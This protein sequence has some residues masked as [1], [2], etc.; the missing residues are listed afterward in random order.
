[1]TETENL[2]REAVQ[3]HRA[4]ALERAETLYRAILACAPAH[5]D[6]CHLLGLIAQSRGDLDDA[7]GLIRSALDAK[8]REPAF[9]CSLA[10]VLRDAGRPEQAIAAY[11]EALRLDSDSADA[12]LNLGN[13]LFECGRLD[14]ARPVYEHALERRPDWVAAHANLAQ[15]LHRLGETEAAVRS[16]ERAL[17]LEPGNA[18][19]LTALGRVHQENGSPQAAR[20][21][22]ETALASDPYHA[23]AHNNLGTLWREQGDLVQAG[24]CFER[25]QACDPADAEVVNNLATVRREQGELDAAE[26]AYRRALTLDPRLAAAHKNLGDVLEALGRRAE[27]LRCYAEA[28]TLRPDF[29][30]ARHKLAALGGTPAPPAAAPE[31]VTELFD[32][33]APEFEAHLLGRLEYRAPQLL[34]AV[35]RGL[36]PEGRYE[37]LDLG[38]GTGLA[39]L[40]VQDLAHHL[41]GIDLSPKMLEQARRRGIYHRL[42]QGE[43]VETLNGLEAQYDLVLAA[44]VLVYLGDLAPA[45]RAVARVLRTGGLFAA[46]LETHRGDGFVLRPSGR[47]AHAPD[48]ARATAAACGLRL[49]RMETAVL[50]REQGRALDGYCVVLGS[51]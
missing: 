49:L 7:L 20:R 11:R 6:A 24:A 3:W 21:C 15:L 47:Y 10:N 36:L 14:Q 12:W 39:G 40:A 9:H 45:L 26:A 1:M 16:Y 27:A 46:S 4:G 28:L 23:A 32:G 51:G 25:A 33:Y 31:Y 5:P 43:L 50:R 37:V 48:Y 13:L 30:E 18:A 17:E 44:D 8:P 2:L 41:S 38:C 35:L 19:V 42:L 22:Y 29:P 34:R